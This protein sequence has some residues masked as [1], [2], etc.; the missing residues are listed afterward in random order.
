[1]AFLLM[2]LFTKKQ[3]KSQQMAERYMQDNFSVCPKCGSNKLDFY[4]SYSVWDI[5][6]DYDA[7]WHR[8]HVARVSYSPFAR[9]QRCHEK[10]S[11]TFDREGNRYTS[12]DEPSEWLI[13]PSEFLKELR[14]GIEGS[15]NK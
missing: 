8:S 10:I 2:N 15:L 9:C 7:P 1:M 13:P 4:N 6:I 14:R 11:S 12:S 3:K 5:S